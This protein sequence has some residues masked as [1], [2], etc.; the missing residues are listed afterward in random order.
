[1]PGGRSFIVVKGTGNRRRSTAQK[2]TLALSKVNK[3]QRSIEMKHSDTATTANVLDAGIE[4]RFDNIAQGDTEV[5]RTGTRIMPKGLQVRYRVDF[6]PASTSSAQSIRLIFVQA[7]TTIAQA[8]PQLENIIDVSTSM[9][10]TLSHYTWEDS[11]GY[12]ILRDVTHEMSEIAGSPFQ[13][14]RQFRI[15]SKKLKQIRYTPG[16]ST[17]E[18]GNIGVIVISNAASLGPIVTIAA[19]LL[20]QDP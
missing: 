15:S 19:R 6:E 10:E 14:S 18:F 8:T 11:Q 20:F 17:V 2:A 4:V 7:K 3:I 9:L 12:R 13:I 5:T 1:M 16:A